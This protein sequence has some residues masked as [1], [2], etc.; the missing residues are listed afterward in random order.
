MIPL[1]W[2]DPW[3][4]PLFLAGCL[5]GLLG[6]ALTYLGLLRGPAEQRMLSGHW[7]AWWMRTIL[8]TVFAFNGGALWLFG[9][10]QHGLATMVATAA[11]LG[12]GLAQVLLWLPC[13]RR[14]RG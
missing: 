11:A 4:W 12:L 6:T 8:V 2:I 10:A 13:P 14:N 3:F 1:S 7:P 9:A 5:A